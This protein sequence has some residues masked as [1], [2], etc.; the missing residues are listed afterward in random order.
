MERTLAILK[1][2]CIK[3]KFMGKVLDRIEQNG[4]KIIGLKMI[5]MTEPVAKGFYAVHKDKSFF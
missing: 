5:Q 2:D 1:P 4:F 3:Q